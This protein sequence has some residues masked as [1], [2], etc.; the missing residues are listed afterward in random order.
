MWEKL[1]LHAFWLEVSLFQLYYQHQEQQ[2]PWNPLSHLCYSTL[3]LRPRN[4]SVSSL[5]SSKMS[6]NLPPLVSYCKPPRSYRQA[7]MHTHNHMHR[8][9]QGRGDLRTSLVLLKLWLTLNSGYIA[10]GVI[11]LNIEN[12]HRRKFHNF[13]LPFAF[14]EGHFLNFMM[15]FQPVPLA[16]QGPAERQPWPWFALIWKNWDVAFRLLILQV[17]DEDF[18]TQNRRLRDATSFWVLWNIN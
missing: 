6:W 16:C 1:S 12:V 9:I 3:Q 2:Q 10:L 15:F 18:R 11:L 14:Q 17:T 5:V 13:F 8:T 4:S 7:V